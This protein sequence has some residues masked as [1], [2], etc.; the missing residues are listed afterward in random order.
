MNVVAQIAVV[1]AGLVHV[2]IF[3]MESLLFTRVQVYRRFLTR[4]EDVTAVQPWAFNQG[5]YNLFL[6]AG[7]IGGVITI[8][9]GYATI[10][11]SVAL[12]SCAC[13]LG[14]ALVL[15][16]SDRRMLRGALMQG[17]LPLV[18]LLVAITSG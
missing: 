4:A 3:A 9:A 16:G 8:H 2:L 12:F 13:M 10:G 1:L 15:I 5:W 14:A 6:A 11:R 18:A 7:A 17:L